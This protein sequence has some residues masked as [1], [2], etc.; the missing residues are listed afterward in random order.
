[1]GSHSLGLSFLGE[2]A[3]EEEEEALHLGIERLPGERVL[4]GG[5]EMGELVLHRL[6][7]DAASGCFEVEVRCTSGA[8]G[9]GGEGSHGW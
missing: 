2:I 8:V 7:R 9:R 4:D 3:S 1:M 6:C 5:D